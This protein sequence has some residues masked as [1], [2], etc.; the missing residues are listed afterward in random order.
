MEHLFTVLIVLLY[1]SKYFLGQCATELSGSKI[2]GCSCLPMLLPAV[3][4]QS[5]QEALAH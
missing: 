4:R 5:R 1:L 3:T 2:V